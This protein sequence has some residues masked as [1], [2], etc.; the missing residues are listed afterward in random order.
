MLNN[1]EIYT[2]KVNNFTTMNKQKNKFYLHHNINKHFFYSVYK[3]RNYF[4]IFYF[5][6]PKNYK[7]IK[8]L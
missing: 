3:Y 1:Y 4:N 7:N 5:H 6:N 8:K 2:K